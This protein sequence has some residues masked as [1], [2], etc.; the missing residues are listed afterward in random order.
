VIGDDF[1][2]V[3]AAAQTGDKDALTTIYRDT[4]PLVLGFAR[5]RGTFE[6]DDIT[7]EVFVSVVKGI[8]GFDGDEQHFRSWLLTIA[9]HRVVDALR[10]QG[11]RPEDPVPTDEL[12]E[13]VLV[14]TDGES[15]AMQRLR[16]AGVLEAIDRLTEDQRAVLLL[17]VLADLPVRDIAAVVGKPESAVKALLRRA[18]ASLHRLVAA[19]DLEVDEP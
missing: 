3:L 18:I 11:R 17:R 13:R 7:S 1:P 8:A 16:A 14:L 10:R 15:E 6:P 2:R 5:S 19:D 12:G 4:A 9:H